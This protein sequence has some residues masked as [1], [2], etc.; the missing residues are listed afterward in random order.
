MKRVT[1]AADIDGRRGLQLEGD[2]G[3]RGLVNGQRIPNSSREHM[4][5]ER[6]SLRAGWRVEDMGEDLP[7]ASAESA[8]LPA[9]TWGGLSCGFRC[10]SREGKSGRSRQQGNKSKTGCP[11]C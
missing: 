10:S 6:R 4:D 9:T 8:R 11:R 7:H 2:V 5:I 1:H 3:R